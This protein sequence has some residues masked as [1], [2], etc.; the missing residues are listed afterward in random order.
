MFKSLESMV[1]GDKLKSE[2]KPPNV[3]FGPGFEKPKSVT[4]F[5]LENV[6]ISNYE[7][8]TEHSQKVKSVSS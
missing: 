1:E 2:I 5:N 8:I 3:E 6:N 4:Q 7:G